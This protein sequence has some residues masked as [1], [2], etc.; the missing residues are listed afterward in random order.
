MPGGR[1]RSLITDIIGI[2]NPHRR[3]DGVGPFVVQRLKKETTRAQAMRL[4]SADHL[5]PGMVEDLH[6]FDRIILVDA[7]T[8]RLEQGWKRETVKPAS[9]FLP[10]LMHHMKPSMLLGLMKSIYGRCPPTWLFTVQGFDFG[11]GEGL[12]LRGPGK[13]GRGGIHDP[14]ICRKDGRGIRESMEENKRPAATGRG[15][16]LTASGGFRTGVRHGQ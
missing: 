14:A 5:E 3:D 8:I 10:Y 4:Q 12:T 13:G 16:D 6:A 1:G 11:L 9:N 15:N 7:T 2:G